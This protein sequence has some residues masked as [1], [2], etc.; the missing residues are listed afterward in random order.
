MYKAVENQNV[1]IAIYLI[2]FNF[3]K[4]EIEIK[5]TKAPR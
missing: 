1:K 3:I 5:K 2:F 4:R